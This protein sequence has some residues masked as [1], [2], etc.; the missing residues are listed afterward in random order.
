MSQGICWSYFPILI[1]FYMGSYERYNT[2]YLCIINCCFV[3]PN[4]LDIDAE[5]IQSYVMFFFF[6]GENLVSKPANETKATSETSNAKIPRGVILSKF[7]QLL[8]STATTTSE[9]TQQHYKSSYSSVV[10]S[11]SYNTL[12]WVS[13][14]PRPSSTNAAFTFGTTK[15]TLAGV[16]IVPLCNASA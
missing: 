4:V 13:L 9:T 2:Y 11:W 14:P 16:W 15:K 6:S 3:N 5:N 8:C 7:A 1:P 12:P 10:P